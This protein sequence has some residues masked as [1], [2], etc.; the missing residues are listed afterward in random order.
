M[1]RYFI[2][3]IMIFIIFTLSA[4][5]SKAESLFGEQQKA[6]DNSIEYIKNSSFRFKENINYDIVK[7][8]LAKENTWEIV[9][10]PDYKISKNMIDTTDLI[11]TIGDIN[12]GHNYAMIVCDGMTYEVIGSIPKE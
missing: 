5:S 9:R 6:V 4:C 12:S 7:I 1:K 2:I 11:I 3:L 8:E 10:H